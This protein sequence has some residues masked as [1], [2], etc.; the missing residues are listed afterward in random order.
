MEKAVKNFLVPFEPSFSLSKASSMPPSTA[1]APEVLKQ[2]S[3]DRIKEIGDLQKVFF[4]AKQYS[5]LLIF[6]G[7]DASGKDGSVRELLSGINPAG[8]L[9]T[10]FK[11]PTSIEMD[12]DFLW[13]ATNRLPGLGVIGVF[14]RSYYE[15]TLVVRV[16]PD[17][18]PPWQQQQVKKEPRKF[19]QN[20]FETINAYEKHLALSRTIVI[21][22]W[23]NLSKE[24]QK[25]RFL[26]RLDQ[27]HHNWKFSP[28]DI[29]ERKFFAQYQE[30]AQEM[31]RQTSTEYAPWYALPADDKHYLH[32]SIAT[33][34][35]AKLKSLKLE[36]P[37]I[38]AN[39]KERFAEIRKMLLNEKK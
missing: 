34:V 39:E 32:A 20:R 28:Q 7:L 23:L 9:V 27:P 29:A 35:S 22:F 5:L 26:I 19:W 3:A 37:K 38:S 25:K 4:A 10:S 13:R 15:E 18:F 1:P 6:Q 31:L 2:V 11:Q 36:Y 30:V 17:I 8:C 14:N 16:H 24:E 33:I 21:K 12:H